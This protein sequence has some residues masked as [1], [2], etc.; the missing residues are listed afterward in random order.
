MEQEKNQLDKSPTE[1]YNSLSVTQISTIE[2]LANK[3]GLP[4]DILDLIEISIEFEPGNKTSISRLLSEMLLRPAE[5]Q[6]FRDKAEE[7]VKLIG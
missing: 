6:E 3:A 5:M 4:E 7:L 1:L 2:K